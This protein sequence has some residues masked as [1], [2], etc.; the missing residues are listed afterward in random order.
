VKAPQNSFRL[1]V[2][3]RS[4]L[5][6]DNLFDDSRL[7]NRL[8]RGVFHTVTIAGVLRGGIDEGMGPRVIDTRSGWQ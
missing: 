6:Y 1:I 8:M 2:K 7:V 4:T 3:H 5:S